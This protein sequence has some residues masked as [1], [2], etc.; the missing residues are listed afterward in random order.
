M[1]VAIVQL[2]RR[3]SREKHGSDWPP[4]MGEITTRYPDWYVRVGSQKIRI[5][6][7]FW[8][9]DTKWIRNF[10]TIHVFQYLHY[11]CLGLFITL[12]L[13]SDRLLPCYSDQEDVGSFW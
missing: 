7:P 5:Q 13:Q 8:V 9:E 11:F 4:K 2:V 10:R 12:V 3:L 6:P 1:Y